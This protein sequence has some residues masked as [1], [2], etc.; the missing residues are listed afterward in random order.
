MG[1]LEYSVPDNI[2]NSCSPAGL[3]EEFRDLGSW[4]HMMVRVA[5]LPYES[6][7]RNWRSYFWGTEDWG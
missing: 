6:R 2:F 4:T 5:V 3:R 1:R 7:S